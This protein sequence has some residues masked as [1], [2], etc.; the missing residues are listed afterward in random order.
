[1]D[2]KVKVEY[3]A[4]PLED[5]EKASGKAH[6]N[7]DGLPIHFV[8]NAAHDCHFKRSYERRKA[9]R[10]ALILILVKFHDEDQFLW[11]EVLEPST[12]NVVGDCYTSPRLHSLPGFP[13]S[14]KCEPNIK[15][16]GPSELLIDPTT[17]SGLIFRVKG[18]FA[19]GSVTIRQDSQSKGSINITNSIYIGSESLQEKIDVKISYSDGD[20]LITV[21]TPS[22]NF[23]PSCILVDTIITLPSSINVFRSIS[24]DAPNNWITVNSL[25]NVDFA[26]VNLKTSN[27]HIRINSLTAA[28]A[29]I[30]TVNGHV[31]GAV[32]VGEN[33]EVRS[34]NGPIHLTAT[35]NPLSDSVFVGL[36]SF[37]G[38][39]N[40]KVDE[41]MKT[42]KID[43]K[44]HSVNGGIIARY[45]YVEGE[46]ITFEKDTRNHKEGYKGKINKKHNCKYNKLGY[47]SN[48]N[49]T[50]VTGA[51]ELYFP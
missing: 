2:N 4:V 47:N 23:P 25:D 16:D 15:W 11:V 31:N 33:L 10:R 18:L 8:N 24:V 38:N 5:S 21:D 6:S 46:G 44:G 20:S 37:N 17:T 43:L 28:N 13:I 19:R 22:F 7:K 9:W 1:M 35:P 48:V 49:L 14:P 12:D 27:G 42:Q 45:A 51:S 34:I 36:S 30:S 32:V 40:I 39:L 29:D 3:T 50:V 26:Y 41:L